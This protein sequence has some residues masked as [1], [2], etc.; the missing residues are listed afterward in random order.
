MCPPLQLK[1]LRLQLVDPPGLDLEVL[2][3]LG[4]V[5]VLGLDLA[6]FPLDLLVPPVE[7]VQ[8]AG[9]P[10]ALVVRGLGL[11]LGQAGVREGGPDRQDQASGV[12]VVLPKLATMKMITIVT[13]TAPHLQLIMPG[14]GLLQAVDGRPHLGQ[15]LA[16]RVPLLLQ[17]VDRGDILQGGE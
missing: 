11:R 14:L 16:Q 3:A 9:Q 5:P 1:V 2:Y 8:L 10:Q 12:L 15:G 4:E 6:V 13:T 17:G 7:G